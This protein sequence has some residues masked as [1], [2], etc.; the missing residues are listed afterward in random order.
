MA[1]F[2]RSVWPYFHGTGTRSSLSGSDTR[3]KRDVYASVWANV[4]IWPSSTDRRYRIPQFI[5]ACLG[6]Q[7]STVKIL[8]DGKRFVRRRPFRHCTRIRAFS[9]RFAGLA[10]RRK[11]DR[12]SGRMDT[13]TSSIGP[14]L[15]RR[16]THVNS[17]CESS[18]SWRCAL[19]AGMIDTFVS[20]KI[21]S[22]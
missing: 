8:N 4:C 17:F 21:R 5:S 18:L 12:S 19:F 9:F 10:W 6:Y 13:L 2:G 1:R 15:L 3:I 20:F 7:R 16:F 14:R 22:R 11:M